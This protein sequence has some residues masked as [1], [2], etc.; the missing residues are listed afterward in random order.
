MIYPQEIEVWYILPAIRREL[1][2]HLINS[3]L[4]QKEVAV[5]LG[6]TEAAV[7]QYMKDK[8][9]NEIAFDVTIKKAIEKAA[10]RLII[11]NNVMREITRINDAMRKNKSICK[12]HHKYDKNLP[13]H[14]DI[15][16]YE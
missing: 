7:S 1:A 10:K 15:C 5:K 13:E 16:I 8:R 3:G 6:V 14:C 12:I 4:K 9:A 11:N 2:K